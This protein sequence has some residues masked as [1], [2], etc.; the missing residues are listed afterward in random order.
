MRRRFERA[1]NLDF[2][3]GKITAIDTHWIWQDG[4]HL[5]KNPFKILG[6]VLTVPETPGL[7][8]QVDMDAVEKAHQLY[9]TMGLGARDD[10]TAMQ[11]L[12]PGWTFDNKR[13]C[14]VR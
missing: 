6:G 9:R 2:H 3:P 7:G 5:T 1:G 12:I 4:Q 13:P 8:V 11:Y 10:A 14:L